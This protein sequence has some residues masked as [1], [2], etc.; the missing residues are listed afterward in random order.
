[1]GKKY[2]FLFFCMLIAKVTLSQESENRYILEIPS[3]DKVSVF[4]KTLKLLISSKYFIV[5]TDKESGFIQC[6]TVID[7]KR[8][9]SRKKGEVIHFNF[10]INSMDSTSTNIYI[11]ANLTVKNFTGSVGDSGY[12]NDDYGI[13]DSKKYLD[14]IVNFLKSHLIQ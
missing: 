1:M 8:L 12:F 2:F 11:Q 14:P 5:S 10:L 7:D 9:V 13:T 4:E 6:K 3:V